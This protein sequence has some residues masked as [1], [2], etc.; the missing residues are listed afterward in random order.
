MSCSTLGLDTKCGIHFRAN[1]E[2]FAWFR[3]TFH[4]RLEFTARAEMIG[5]AFVVRDK[6]WREVH[7]S[8]PARHLGKSVK[9]P[10]GL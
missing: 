10:D 9:K 8:K 4:Q 5:A 2:S 7:A 6:C 3:D 1:E